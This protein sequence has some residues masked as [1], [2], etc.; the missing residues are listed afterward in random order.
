[1]ILK[2]MNLS[3]FEEIANIKRHMNELVPEEDKMATIPS[4]LS[5]C[6]FVN[7]ALNLLL[8]FTICCAKYF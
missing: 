3:L 7:N 2:L 6:D 4:L 1:M 8:S 5:R